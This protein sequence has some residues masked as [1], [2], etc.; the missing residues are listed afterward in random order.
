MIVWDEKKLKIMNVG[1]LPG[2]KPVQ[3]IR[4]KGGIIYQK[5]I[6]SGK[7]SGQSTIGCISL[8]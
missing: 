3:I 8:I 2:A 1:T 5:A 7:G 6:V 4:T